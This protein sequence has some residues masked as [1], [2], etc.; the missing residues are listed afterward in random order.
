MAS[1]SSAARRNR[2]PWMTESNGRKKGPRQSFLMWPA[3]R[4]D[5]LRKQ[6]ASQ[7]DAVTICVEDGVLPERKEEARRIASEAL[8]TYDYGTKERFVRINGLDTEYWLDDLE[9]FCRE[10]PPT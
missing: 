5:L 7:A 3:D 9:H 1:S 4:P 8:R 6:A 10:A 2:G